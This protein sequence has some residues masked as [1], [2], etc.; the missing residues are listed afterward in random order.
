MAKA[1]AGVTEECRT[2]A[3]W[4]RSGYEVTH[5]SKALFQAVLIWASKGDDARYTASF[6]GASQV[7]PIKA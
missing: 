3:D 6:F 5:G 1:A 4:H 7:Y 2:W